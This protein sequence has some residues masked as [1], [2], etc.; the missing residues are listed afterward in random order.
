MEPLSVLSVTL[1]NCGKTFGWIKMK[2]GMQVGVGPGHIV[3]DG[4][5]DSP[6]Q[7]RGHVQPPI[8]GP[9]L[10]WPNGWMDQDAT[11]YVDRP[12]PR[13]RS[14]RWEPSSTPPKGHSPPIFGPCLLW[15]LW[16]NGRPSQLFLSTCFVQH[17]LNVR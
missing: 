1:V 16:P 12:Q 9:C 17:T 15:D 10:L 3:L 14:V 5:P 11:W 8:F 13:P 7:N 6:S 4:D 2:L